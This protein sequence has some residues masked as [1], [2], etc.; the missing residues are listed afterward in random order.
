MGLLFNSQP[1]FYEDKEGRGIAVISVHSLCFYQFEHE[2]N[3]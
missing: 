2:E 1:I 3:S